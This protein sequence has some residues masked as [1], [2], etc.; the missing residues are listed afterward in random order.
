MAR[1][2]IGIIGLGMAI[3]PHA[4]SLIDLADRVEVAGAFSRTAERRNAFAEKFDFPLTD[5]MDAIIDDASLHAV[6]LLTTP[7][8]HLDAVRRCAAAGKH[9]LMEKPLEISSMRA[10]ELI[11][12]CRDAGVRLG[13]VLQHRF[14]PASEKLAG[15][16]ASGRLGEL[17]GTTVY[18]HIWR[19][20]SYYDQPGR[21]DRNRDGG[22]VLLTQ[23]IHPIDLFVSLAG[24]PA[25]VTAFAGTS[26]LHRMETEDIAAAAMRYHN[27]AMG[28]LDATTTAF[29]G[30]PERIELICE[31]GAAILEG[32]LNLRVAYHD[33]TEEVFE[34]DETPGGTGADPMSGSYAHHKA[35]LVDFLDAL[36]QGRDPRITGEEALKVHR[37]IDAILESAEQRR[38]V[39]VIRD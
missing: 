35:V 9:I 26:R 33:G 3:A 31:H 16:L 20:Q 39:A 34:S 22:G 38:P 10:V 23:G 17:V 18:I 24:Q 29:P 12:T 5:S 32:G 19:P 1:K 27:G 8:N 14:R 7:D 6:L 15:I 21:G 2:R 30:A 13:I 25:E 11:G 36:D 4:R 37:L 28:T